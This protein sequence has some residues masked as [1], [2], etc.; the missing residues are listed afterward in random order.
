MEELNDDIARQEELIA[1]QKLEE[2][3]ELDFESLEAVGIGA[4]S[5]A[6]AERSFQ[7]VTRASSRR[8]GMFGPEIADI[9]DQQAQ[10][11]CEK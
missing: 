9:V 1:L 2:Q 5:E 4:N 10:L 8:D 7:M 3:T 11:V 6:A